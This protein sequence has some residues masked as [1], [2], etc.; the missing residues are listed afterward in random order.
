M[1]RTGILL[2]ALVLLVLPAAAQED[3]YEKGFKSITERELKHYVRTL[4]SD[5]YEGR[6][7]GTKHCDNAGKYIEGE[8]K[9]MKVSAIPGTKEHLARFEIAVPPTVKKTTR[10]TIESGRDKKSLELAK[11]YLPLPFSASKEVEAEVVFAGYGITAPEYDYDDYAGIDA[12]G[13]IV[14]VMRY[15]PQRKSSKSKFKGK[16]YTKHSRFSEKIA[17]AEKH[18]AA[19]LIIMT[20]PLDYDR[21]RS[22][23]GGLRFGSMET[24]K[25][26]VV[27]ATLPVADWLFKQG[28][29]ALEYLQRDIDSDCEPRSF[30]FEKVTARVKVELEHARAKTFN[31]IACCPGSDSRLADEYL[32][33]GAH[34]DHIGRGMYMFPGMGARRAICNGADDNASGTAAVLELAEAFGLLKKKPKRSVLFVLF[35]G[36]E[37]GLLGSKAFVEKPPVPLEKIVFMMNFDMIGRNP[38]NMTAAGAGTAPGLKGIV[39]AAN[40]KIRMPLKLRDGVGGGSDHLPFYKKKIPV[41]YFLAGTH[42]DYHR[43]GDDWNKLNYEDMEKVT[44]VAFN[45]LTRIADLPERP[46]FAEGL[47]PAETVAYLGIEAE[48]VKEPG[49]GALIKKVVAGSP[50]AEAGVKEGDVA[51]EF[52]GRVVHSV[53]DLKGE[54]FEKS[55]GMEVEL[56][57]VRNEEE[58]R[59]KIKLGKR[60]DF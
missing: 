59:L 20:P 16:E 12:K 46:K 55:Q 8:L 23:F 15:E 21:T 52:G 31:V 2:V 11:T 30:A 60:K 32:V 4:A 49:T 42:E 26:P 35:S 13:K 41:V 36:E 45:V 48:D 56:V 51:V 34:Y 58:V 10:L 44:K 1:K 22:E 18:G 24:A 53:E 25:I 28:P 47:H 14:I 6:L 39:N 50:A 54:L 43:P 17:N 5:R 19:G 9:K 27:Y 37:R 57:V 3:K 38:G 29:K 40:N 7:S 33:V